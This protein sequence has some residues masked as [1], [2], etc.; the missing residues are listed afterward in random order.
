[1]TPVFGH[2]R[3]RLYL[4]RLLDESPRHG[5]Q[6][7][8]LLEDRF[9]GRYVPSAGTI[10]PRLRRLEAEGLVTHSQSSG[11][12]VYRLTDAGRAELRDRA[13]EMADLETQ[14][15]AAVRELAHEVGEQVRDTARDLHAEVRATRDLRAAERDQPAWQ[16]FLAYLEQRGQRDRSEERFS[17]N[18]GAPGW[19]NPP[20][21]RDGSSRPRPL[22]WPTARTSATSSTI[23]SG[24][25]TRS[26]IW[27][28]RRCGMARSARSNCKNVHRSSPIPSFRYGPSFSVG[29]DCRISQVHAIYLAGS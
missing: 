23:S 17:R 19:Q 6:L 22:R 8:R 24:F 20:G 16:S 3:L 25:A 2:G 5:Y 12:K 7:I 29:D 28:T 26:A 14:I 27:C 15:G 4:L 11:R 1:M 10:Y 21:R 13:G 18:A 9:E